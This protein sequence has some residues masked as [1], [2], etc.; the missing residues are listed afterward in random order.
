MI[1]TQIQLEEAQMR[2]L[3]R[4][5]AAEGRSLADLVREGVD[6][7]LQRRGA[8]DPGEVRRRALAVVG[9]VTKAPPD[10]STNHDRYL[11]EA[12]DT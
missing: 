6:L 5:G 4:L 1:R 9:L 11:D 8:P 12:F 10:L 7:L 3:R 2:R